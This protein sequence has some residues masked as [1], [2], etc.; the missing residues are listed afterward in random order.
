MFENTKLKW[1]F[2]FVRNPISW[3]AHIETILNIEEQTTENTLLLDKE[4]IIDVLDEYL[5]NC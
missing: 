5:N 3:I 2:D 4:E 1:S